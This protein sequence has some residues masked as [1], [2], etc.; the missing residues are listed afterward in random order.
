MC[1]PRGDDD[2]GGSAGRARDALRGW[3]EDFLRGRL[4]H[5]SASG[6]TLSGIKCEG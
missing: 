1:L 4:L 2:G 3:L 6:R 5:G